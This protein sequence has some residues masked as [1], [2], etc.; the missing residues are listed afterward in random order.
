M[1]EVGWEGEWRVPRYSLAHPDRHRIDDRKEGV[2]G[3]VD[4]AI[5]DKP[6][7]PA[8]HLL[9]QN[10]QL[11]LGKARA[12]AAVDAVSERKVPPRVGAIH[13]KQASVRK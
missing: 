10:L 5:G 9:H 11:Q 7:I 13:Q 3:P 1:A 4:F 2:R 6:Y 12:D 8:E